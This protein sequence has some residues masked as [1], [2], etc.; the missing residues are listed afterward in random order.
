[1]PSVRTD[2]ALPMAH[3]PSLRD[4]G[5]PVIPP[6]PHSSRTSLDGGHQVR[7][8]ILVLGIVLA[9]VAVAIVAAVVVVA[10]RSRHHAVPVVRERT[11]EASVAN[12]DD[13]DAGPEPTVAPAPTLSAE[14]APKWHPR[15]GGAP[16]PCGALRRARDRDASAA[17]VTKL[18]ERCRATGGEP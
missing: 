13:D 1:P 5:P 11:A 8:P 9:V 6:H 12:P 17:V 2:V 14:P 18:Q 10:T 15:D 4:G 7:T 16:D 3:A